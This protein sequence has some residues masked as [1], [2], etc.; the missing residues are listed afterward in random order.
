[1]RADVDEKI[2]GMCSECKKDIKK[3]TCTRCGK[4]IGDKEKLE[5]NVKFDED[6]FKSLAGDIDG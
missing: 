1:M 6:K 2:E 3:N 5:T 4:V